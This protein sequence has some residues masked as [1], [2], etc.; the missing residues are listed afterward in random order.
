MKKGLSTLLTAGLLSLFSAQNILQ[1][2]EPMFWWKGMK[3]PELQIMLYGKDIANNT[4][5]LSDNVPVENITKVDNPN[6]VFVTINTTQVPGSKFKIQVKNKKKV[7]GSYTYEL[8]D[9][10]A[11]SAERD[12]YSSKDV[13]YLLMPD[14]FANGNPKNDSTKDT[15]EKADLNNPNGRHGGDLAGIIDHLD[16][17]QDLGVTAVWSTPLLEDNE[18]QGSY[19][20]YAVS[21]LYKI[22]PRF[23]SNAD[24]KNLADQ[25]HQRKMKL[26]MDYV[27]NHWGSQS[28]IIKDL[29]SKD[30]IHYWPNG[31]NGF[32]RSSYQITTQFDPY[33]AQV[34]KD[35]ADDGWFD[36]SMPDM[37]QKNPLV[38]NYMI[39][40]AIW[41]IEYAGLDGFRVDTYPYNDKQGIAKWTKAITEEYPNFNIVGEVWLHNQAQ[42]AYWQKDSKVGAIENYN[43]HLPSVM[44]FTLQDAISAG[45]REPAGWN[46]GAMR[47]YDNFVN[48][49]L[50]PDPKNILVFMENHDTDRFNQLYPEVSDY[51]LA[52]TLIATTRGIP[53]IL[54]GSEIGMAGDK[55][56]GDGYI[57]QDFPGGWPGDKSDAFISTGRT[58]KQ[59]E[60]FDFTKKILN[61]RKGNEVISDG[62]MLQYLP[63][64]NIYVYFRY[65][66]HKRVMVILN[67]DKNDHTLVLGRFSQGIQQFKQGKDVLS[68]KTFDL[69]SP[70]PL[71]VPAKTSFVLELQ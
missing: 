24:Y 18:P 50:Y 2:V 44:D 33:V 17:L 28:W 47:F 12:S 23:G 62:K 31:K 19:H 7:V 40:N 14:R 42:I 61:W 8:K 3:N 25:L 58:E 49:F 6:Y 36:T 69:K 48:D 26:I 34:D 59:N 29:P 41:W 16:Y 45:L 1:H 15:F 64:N 43:S 22:D 57:R 68:G 20:G 38:L 35:L 55:S 52:L 5:T 39:Q 56:K 66:D 10:E 46:T 11:G 32:V 70:Q 53:Q 30:W 63:E 67:L 65:N 54:Y 51:K 4:I 21:D 27:T 37:N 9:R 13:I 71:L 60:Y